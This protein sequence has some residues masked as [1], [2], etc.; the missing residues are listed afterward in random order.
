MGDQ[1]IVDPVGDQQLTGRRSRLHPR[2][3]VHDVAER[4]EVDHGVADIAHVRHRGR[5][6]ARIGCAVNAGVAY[7]GNVGDAV[8]DFTA[9]GDVVNVAAQ[10]QA[11]AAAGELL[12]ADGIDDELIAHAPRR[13]LELRGREQPV[14]AFVLA[15]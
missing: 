2:G 8:V 6:L 1:L 7:V 4:G 9:L 10:M 14:D 3:D 13:R 11:A 12:V 15:A 5:A